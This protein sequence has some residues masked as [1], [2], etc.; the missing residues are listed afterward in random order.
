[1]HPSEI[2]KYLIER[3]ENEHDNIA[4]RIVDGSFRKDIVETNFAVGQCKGLRGA[5]DI[6]EAAFSELSGDNLRKKEST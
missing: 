6:I 3:I 1:M 4:S 5:C 2:K